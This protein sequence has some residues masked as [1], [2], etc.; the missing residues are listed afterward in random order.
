MKTPENPN[1]PETPLTPGNAISP[2]NV[3]SPGNADLPIGGRDQYA[4][5]EIWRSQ[6]EA[7]P[8]L[9]FLSFPAFPIHALVS[10]GTA[11]GICRTLTATR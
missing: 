11:G 7:F 5:Q 6:G 10:G 2:G 4:N 9:A 8:G 3:I 1:P